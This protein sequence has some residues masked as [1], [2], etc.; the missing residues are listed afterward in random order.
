MACTNCKKKKKELEK[1]KSPSKSPV[2]I[3]RAITWIIII[4]FLL[5][6]YGLWSLIEKIFHL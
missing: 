3:D 5:G 2:K 4:W 1:L 6:V